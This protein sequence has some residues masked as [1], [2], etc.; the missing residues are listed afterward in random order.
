MNDGLTDLMYRIPS[1]FQG[2][3]KN[4]TVFRRQPSCVEGRNQ[5]VILEETRSEIGRQRRSS[6]VQDVRQAEEVI[7]MINYCE[8]IN[9]RLL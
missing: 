8:A 9:T 5:E 1:A 2:C 6:W 7:G 3:H 4:A